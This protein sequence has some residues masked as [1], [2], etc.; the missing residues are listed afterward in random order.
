MLPGW[1]SIRSNVLLQL[2]AA[3]TNCYMHQVATCIDLQTSKLDDV[4]INNQLHKKS[5]RKCS[6]MRS[7]TSLSNIG[8]KLYL[9]VDEVLLNC[10]I[11]V[12]PSNAA[13]T[14]TSR[15]PCRRVTLRARTLR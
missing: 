15:G 14:A 12:G 2:A 6:E 1:L 10:G 4:P 13:L 5:I 9:D 7:C 11:G 8:E 3:V